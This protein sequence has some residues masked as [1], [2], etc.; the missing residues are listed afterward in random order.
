[1]Q[2]ITTD[3][4]P[5]RHAKFLY[6][7]G[8]S[9]TAIADHLGEQR[10]TVGSW[11]RRDDWDKAPVIERIEGA[12]EYRL[13][14]LLVKSEKSGGDYKEI[15]LLSRQMERYARVRRYLGG[16]NET[17]LNPNIAQRNEKK[18][19]H[20]NA[21]TDEQIEKLVEAFD[22]A[23]FAYQDV[24]WRN[25]NQRTR[26]ILKSRQIGATWFFAREAFID[27]LLT[28]RNQI[29]ISASKAQ[30]HVFKQYILQFVK[31]TVDVD[32]R[33]DPIVLHNGATL[34]FL[35]TNFRTAQSY[36]GNL[37]VDEFFWIPG[38]ERLNKVASAMAVHKKWRKT[39][40]S[41]PSA[42]S[43]EAYPFWAGERKKKRRGDEPGQVKMD[44]SHDTLKAGKLCADKIWRQIVTV[45]DAEAG[46][47]NLF[48]IEEL[49]DEYTDEDFDNL[50]R[51]I[52]IDDT[53]SVFPWSTL[54]SCMVD[55]WEIWTDYKPH[56]ARPFGNRE[57]WLGYD[58]ASTGDCQG[59]A[60]IAPPAVPGGKFRVL[61]RIQFR[62][63]D[64]QQQADE[65]E[66][67]TKKYN[68][69]YI[70]IDV[71]GMGGAVHELVKKF[72]P[73]VTAITYSVEVK[74][75]MVLKMQ[76]VMRNGR[77]EFD[78]GAVDLAASFMSIRKIITPSGRQ[79]TYASGR[80]QAVGHADLAWAVMHAVA[81]EPL[82]GI[83]ENSQNIME[84]S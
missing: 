39:Y 36:H 41:T 71:T 75:Q 70:G 48:D 50:F 46:G 1:M 6:W 14:Q 57:V 16:G 56:A 72:F 10:S 80:T 5:R 4:D 44:V 77:F 13:V 3:Q 63:L 31:D 51:C 61:E 25:R 69:T 32:L 26:I 40:F 67:L 18:K 24:W 78:A 2:P 60:V 84:I 81:H 54:Q 35:G 62:N 17:D 28:G 8:W 64:Y 7:Q 52:F 27:A 22:D 58:P 47:C 9:L 79:A 76:N 43:H 73:A 33:G 19:A 11:K 30:A 68:V 45:Y 42:M 15:D 82:Q 49:L 12:A 74:T 59:L 34:Y 21:L 55:S 20:K 38:F 53:K 66:K 29:F 65:I 37:Y 83:T 23:T